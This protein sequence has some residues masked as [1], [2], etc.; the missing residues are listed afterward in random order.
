MH[1]ATPT[2]FGPCPLSPW[3]G[4]RPIYLRDDVVPVHLEGVRHDALEEVYKPPV[5]L[6]VDQA[7]FEDA[8]AF[9]AP[10]PNQ[11]LG[12]CY[13]LVAA[14]QYP[15]CRKTRGRDAG[16]AMTDVAFLV[17]VFSRE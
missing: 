14:H 10:Q 6:G 7:V 9:V 4:G 16:Q 17:Y 11:H 12:R 2:C 13:G 15:W 8:L 1:R 5:V 3:R